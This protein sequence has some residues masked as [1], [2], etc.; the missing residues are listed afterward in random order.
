MNFSDYPF[1]RYLPFFIAGILSGNTVPQLDWKGFF[2]FS[3]VLWGIYVLILFR[4]K[5]GSISILGSLAYLI[6]FSLGFSLALV[7]KTS[8]PP[9]FT[10][11]GVDSY[12]GEVINFDKPKTNSSENLLEIVASKD[13]GEWKKTNGRVLIYHQSSIPLKPG[14]VVWVN[15]VPERI[16]PPSFPNEFDYQNFLAK[17]GIHFRQLTKKEILRIDSTA[18]ENPGFVLDRIGHSL[19]QVIND[20]IGRPE[21]RQIAL[22]LL[23]GKK[24]SLDKEIREA[25]SETGTMHILAVSGLHVGIIYAILLLPIRGFKREGTITFFYLILVIF[26]IWL[27]ALLTGFSPSV[28]RASTMFSLMTFG[29]LRRRKSSIWNILAFSAIITLIV[30]PDV[31]FDIGFQLSYVAVAGIVGIQPLIVHWWLPKSPI[32]EYFWQLAAVSLAAQLVT[33]PLSVLYFHQFPS[34]FLLANLLIVP[35]AFLIMSVG[36]PFLVFGQMP[37][38][39]EALAWLLDF[40]I[41]IQ[42]ELTF[43]IQNLPG[44]K[45][46]RL[47]I[48]ISGV[49]LVWG[50]LILWGNWELGNRKKLI[51]IGI[52]LFV[53]WK[54]EHLVK[55]I[56]RPEH[57]LILFKNQRGVIA[58]LRVGDKHLSWNQSFPPDQINFYIDPNRVEKQRSSMPLP[59]TGVILD[60]AIW[61]PGLDVRFFPKN[62]EIYQESK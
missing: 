2:I 37:V 15:K 35:L 34:Y 20:K 40:L 16:P 45:I 39:G 49:V 51:G 56:L 55:E 58:D 43:L 62:G 6:L 46:E 8:V 27:Y 11:E 54:G 32:L 29:Q 52:I 9:S 18:I 47:T 7:R 13:S 57:E 12:F 4:S 24:D 31:I 14:D 22:A 60:S 59:L 38:F 53:V 42:N 1:L 19:A 5:S 30:N 50:L 48:S 3:L 61:F 26:I 23:L 33:F 28:V 10:W 44:G 17:K 21:S 36:V 41:Y 25:Y